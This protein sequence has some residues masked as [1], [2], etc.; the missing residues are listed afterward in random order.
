MGP[1]IREGA[2]ERERGLL[3]D[4]VRGGGESDLQLTQ[5]QAL[6]RSR[7]DRVAFNAPSGRPNGKQYLQRQ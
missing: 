1:G 2:G 3:I 6:T 4:E 5:G 7:R